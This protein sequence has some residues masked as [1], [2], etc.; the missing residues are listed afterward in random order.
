[1]FLLDLLYIYFFL[2][3][4]ALQTPLLIVFRIR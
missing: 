2:Y 3:L 1:M 4:T